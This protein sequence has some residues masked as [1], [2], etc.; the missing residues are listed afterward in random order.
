[1]TFYSLSKLK[2]F[3]LLA[4]LISACN[5]LAPSP[6]SN[7]NSS[8]HAQKRS[9]TIETISKNTEKPLAPLPSSIATNEPLS[10]NP[11]ICSQA[12][13]SELCF[14]MVQ[15]DAVFVSNAQ[16]RLV[17]TQAYI[18]LSEN[19]CQKSRELLSIAYRQEPS[20]IAQG[21]L[22][23]L[24]EQA[25]ECTAG[26]LHFKAIQSQAVGKTSDLSFP[27]LSESSFSEPEVKTLIRQGNDALVQ[28]NCQTAQISY[29]SAL[30]SN[31]DQKQ[32]AFIKLQRQ[33]A[34]RCIQRMDSQIQSPTENVPEPSQSPVTD[35]TLEPTTT[36]SIFSPPPLLQSPAETSAPS[37]SPIPSPTQTDT[38]LPAQ[39]P[40]I[41]T[42]T[43]SPI[44]TQSPMPTPSPIPTP[45][46]LPLTP[47]GCSQLGEGNLRWKHTTTGKIR[48]NPAIG[49]DGSIY[50]TVY[51]TDN[52]R[53]IAIHPDGFLK[54]EYRVPDQIRNAPTVGPDGSIVF[55]NNN[56]RVYALKPDGSVKWI[57]DTQTPYLISSPSIA[58]DGT[59]YFAGGNSRKLFA[60]NPDGTLKWTY[61]PPV[62]NSLTS[63][64]II[65]ADGSIYFSSSNYRYYGLTPN[66]QL[67]WEVLLGSSISTDSSMDEAG[68]IYVTKYKTLYKIKSSDGTILSEA[69]SYEQPLVLVG[70]Q[71][72][73]FTGNK[74]YAQ[75]RLSGNL[76]W[77]WTAKSEAPYIKGA[78]EKMYG[79]FLNTSL[80]FKVLA[81]HADGFTP[82]AYRDPENTVQA[83]ET[84]LTLANDGSLYTAWN[85]R[86]YAV[87][88][89]SQGLGSAPWPK[90]GKDNRNSGQY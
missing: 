6:A 70:P 89:T 54:W 78:D 41:P 87:C 61:T 48:Y 72:L 83:S 24:I 86:I 9:S 73:F 38:L 75:N 25:D 30:F 34:Q 85:N 63:K 39:S 1:M 33:V 32:D 19:Q 17:L 76:D 45:T 44:P 29:E 53:I 67:K 88:T 18:L 7:L 90:W 50:F 46:P 28:K 55:T 82:W 21:Y 79:I 31:K 71:Q 80:G 64:P 40:I 59:V 47:P 36:A 13:G 84:G 68:N 77:S 69:N 51:E 4:L 10:S 74:L 8:S 57:Y 2:Y 3:L 16:V 5:E 49:L 52:H 27:Y 15:P 35:I 60:L 26:A 56:G 23:S 43:P 66:K 58:S 65:G 42:P 81:L 14:A 12:K 62:L 11:V 22:A 20:L 37:S